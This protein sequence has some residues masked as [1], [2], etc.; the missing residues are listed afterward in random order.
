VILIH[1]AVRAQPWQGQKL[2]RNGSASSYR[3]NNTSRY[4]PPRKS[5]GG[6]N[7]SKA[8]PE[9]VVSCATNAEGTSPG[10]SGN[11]SDARRKRRPKLV[12]VWRMSRT[13]SGPMIKLARLL[14]SAQITDL[15]LLAASGSIFV[16]LNYMRAEPFYFFLH[17][18]KS[19]QEPLAWLCA[20]L[21]HKLNDPSF[22][23]EISF[24]P[25]CQLQQAQP[26]LVFWVNFPKSVSRLSTNTIV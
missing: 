26:S 11:K 2:G 1:F 19:M 20:E 4:H 13:I 16:L 5:I 25:V 22:C 23:E 12:P 8:P 10:Q 17:H 18:F 24:V 7:L 3:K 21:T 9:P 14:V 15:P 6:P